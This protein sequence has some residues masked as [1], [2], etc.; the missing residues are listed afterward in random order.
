M[1]MD[2]KK[3]ARNKFEFRSKGRL[4]EVE[5]SGGMVH[6]KDGIDNEVARAHDVSGGMT[7]IARFME[8]DLWEGEDFEIQEQIRQ[9]IRQ[10]ELK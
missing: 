2:F 6:T 10:N 5:V 9:L 8:Q 1:G 3:I 4:L 7:S